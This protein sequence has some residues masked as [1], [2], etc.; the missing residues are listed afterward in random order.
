MKKLKYLLVLL[1]LVPYIVKAD[2]AGPNYESYTMVVTDSKG[3]DYYGTKYEENNP[4]PKV[5]LA[6][7]LNKGE[8]FITNDGGVGKDIIEFFHNDE[9]CI[10]KNLNAVEVVNKKNRKLDPTEKN[11]EISK[12]KGEAIVY[13]K[14]GVDIRKGPSSAYDKI[15]HIKQYEKIEYQYVYGIDGTT[16]IYAEYD[17]K[18]GWISILNGSVYIS[19]GGFYENGTKF[20]AI[21][22]IKLSCG[23]TFP[24]NSIFVPKYYSDNWSFS[25]LIE[26]NGCYGTAKYRFYDDLNV[27][28]FYKRKGTAKKDLS[29]YEFSGSKGKQLGTIP[30]GSKF[31]V[32]ASIVY[33]DCREFG[34]DGSK[35]LETDVYLEYGNIKGWYSGLDSTYGIE[36]PQTSGEEEPQIEE[37]T[38]DNEQEPEL[39]EDEIL[40]EIKKDVEKKNKQKKKD[41]NTVLICVIAGSSISLAALVTIIIVN[42]KRKKKKI[43]LVDNSSLLN[44]NVAAV[45]NN[46]VQDTQMISNNENREDLK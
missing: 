17:G 9:R 45:E 8:T 21:K 29:I 30:K 25:F 2:M 31:T 16:H 35:S 33:G 42:K 10:I 39:S 38:S 24:E 15:G 5:Y 11:E 1:L 40:E 19:D 32:L 41:N 4:N 43:K 23:E 18:K 34:C 12:I 37:E 6:G 7:H 20:I 44:N 46:N 27:L 13:A 28:E 22:E 3:V 14:D 36:Y 26:K